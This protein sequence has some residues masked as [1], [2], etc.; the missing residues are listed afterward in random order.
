MD[1]EVIEILEEYSWPGNIREL[2]NLTQRLVLMVDGAVILPKHLPQQILVT[3]TT[4]QEALLI[5]EQGVNFDEEMA[6]IEAAYVGAA[7]R[8]SGGSKVGAARLLHMDKQKMHYLCRKY[9]VG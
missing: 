7:L 6:R 5:P 8:R 1:H 2:E 9:H 3:T 4:S